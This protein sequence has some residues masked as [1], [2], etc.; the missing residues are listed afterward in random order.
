MLFR[1]WRIMKRRFLSSKHWADW[2]HVFIYLFNAN[3][4]KVF[5]V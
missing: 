4:L 2:K 3:E 5:G 1:M